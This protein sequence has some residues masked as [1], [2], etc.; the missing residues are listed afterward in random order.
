M[1][2]AHRVEPHHPEDPYGE[3]KVDHQDDDEEQH[4]QVEAAFPPAVDADLVDVVGHGPGG[5]DALGGADILLP[6]HL[7]YEDNTC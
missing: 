1:S 4:K 2:S 6:N 3:G 7:L 5:A